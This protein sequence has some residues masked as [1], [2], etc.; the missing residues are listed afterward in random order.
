MEAKTNEELWEYRNQRLRHLVRHACENA[1]AIRAKFDG[2]G[3]KPED[4]QTVKD[5]AKIPVTTKDELVRLQ[6]ETPPFGGFLATPLE[7]LEKIF[8]SPGP[9]FDGG[10]VKERLSRLVE[11][12]DL[13]KVG[14][15]DRVMVTYSYHLVPPAHWMDEAIRAVGATAIPS[16]AGNTDSQVKIMHDLEVTG[17]VGTPSFLNL[18]IKRAEEMGYDFRGDFKL[19]F[20]MTSAEMLP[21]SLRQSFEEKYGIQVVD[22]I[23]TADVGWFSYECE[24]K[25]GYHLS[26]DIIVEIVDPATGRQLGPGELGELVV[27]PFDDSYTLIRFGTGDL[28]A[29]TD[30]PCPCGREPFR[31]LGMKGRVGE[32]VKIRGMFVHPNQ[33]KQCLADFPEVKRFQLQVDQVQYRDVATLRVEAEAGADEE[34]LSAAIIARFPQVCKVKL[35]KVEFLPPDAI[36]LEAKVVVDQRKWE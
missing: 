36:S 26:R 7:N 3:I 33:V 17:Y 35:D 24:Q 4:V 19:R 29:Y 27:T 28:S 9:L 11:M 14:R 15:G 8:L 20:A 31:L 6:K 2:A 10:N 25:S 13:V 12:F 32:A 23:G 30:E 21:P 16:G 5:L 34:R 18:I 22:I 1:P